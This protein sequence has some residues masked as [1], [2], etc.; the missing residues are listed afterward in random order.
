L[1][2]LLRV[3]SITQDDTHH[4]VRHDQ[5]KAEIEMVIA[6]MREVY[7]AFGFTE[8]MVQ[9]S[10]RDSKNLEKY[11]GQDELW[12]QA[13][14]I[15]I[16]A[17]K[18]WGVEYVVEEGEAAFYGPKIDIMVKDAIGRLWQLNTIQLDFWQAENF[19]LS[20]IAED[21]S[22]Q[23]PAVLH[24]AI[25][26]SFERFLG[27]LIEH[28]AGKW[29]LWLA[30]VQVKVLPIADRHEEQAVKVIEELKQ[31]GYRVELDARQESVGKKIRAAQ[32]EQVPYMLV[33]GDKEIEA[34]A[35]AV[36]HRDEGDLG[37]MAVEDLKKRLSD[38][39]NPGM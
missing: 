38:E 25:L 12:S 22:S 35:V 19:D 33:L 29:P 20:Y 28:Y 7:Q 9:I 4:F 32:L 8:F 2:G 13:E 5:I 34:Q 10:L 26:G 37:V 6:L 21:G 1:N 17:V 14:K 31:A 15:L 11:F 23:R 3:K 27:V 18:G 24:V 39:K 16:E 36:R 30:P